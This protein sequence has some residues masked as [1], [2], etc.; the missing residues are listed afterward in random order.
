MKPTTIIVMVIILSSMVTGIL[1]VVFGQVT[2]R[3]LRKNPKTKDVLGG[4]LVSGW[5]ILNVAKALSLPRSWSK[6]LE[7]SALSFMYANSDLLFEHT[8][9][10]DRLLSAMFFLCWLV[11]GFSSLLLIALDSFGFFSE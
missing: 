5:D 8:T 9:K 1:F 2:V 10:F 3:K 6:K 7:N 4:E 11:S